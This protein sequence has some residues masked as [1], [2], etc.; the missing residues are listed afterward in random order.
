M[1]SGRQG[2]G[3]LECINF[4]FL[5]VDSRK[6]PLI[7]LR[8]PTKLFFGFFDLS[9]TSNYGV[10]FTE[11]CQGGY[12][13]DKAIWM[14]S[15]IDLIH[16]WDLFS[17]LGVVAWLQAWTCSC[18]DKIVTSDE[19]Y[20]PFSHWLCDFRDLDESRKFARWPLVPLEEPYSQGWL[21]SDWLNAR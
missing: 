20:L 1:T 4:R 10:I 11:S 7:C 8:V 6:R 21:E 18:F 2:C 5:L 19:W 3:V 14:V 13:T 16:Y 9:R 15:P 17:D 12:E